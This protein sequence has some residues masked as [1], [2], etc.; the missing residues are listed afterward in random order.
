MMKRDRCGEPP[1]ITDRNRE[2]ATKRSFA[3]IAGRQ[4]NQP[5]ASLSRCAWHRNIAAII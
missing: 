2:E 5:I 3:S 4:A 1:V